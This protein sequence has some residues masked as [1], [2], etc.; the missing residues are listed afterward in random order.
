MSLFKC[1]LFLDNL[2]VSQWYEHWKTSIAIK[3]L[4]AMLLPFLR[5]VRKVI[6]PNAVGGIQNNPNQYV[7]S[8][9]TAL[10]PPWPDCLSCGHTC[11]NGLRSSPQSDA[12]LL[13]AGKHKSY[14]CS[15]PKKSSCRNVRISEKH[16]SFVTGLA[17]ALWHLS[18]PWQHRKY[19]HKLVKWK[20]PASLFSRVY[21]EHTLTLRGTGLQWLPCAKQANICKADYL[22]NSRN[23]M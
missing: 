23:Q 20:H 3:Y 21:W 17:V 13:K 15:Y 16:S 22:K 8:N 18:H 11:Q 2:S 9:F 6:Y 1:F 4:R 12:L 14:P 7:E 5:G 10:I 19:Y